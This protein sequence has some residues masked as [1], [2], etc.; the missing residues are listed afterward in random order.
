MPPRSIFTTRPRRRPLMDRY[1]N[2]QFSYGGELWTRADVIRDL[3]RIG[4]DNRM[5][6][7]YLQGAEHKNCLEA[8]SRPPHLPLAITLS[9]DERKPCSL[10]L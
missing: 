9:Y 5:I 7:R 4:A 8:E 10:V 1:M 3:K 2:E 6:D